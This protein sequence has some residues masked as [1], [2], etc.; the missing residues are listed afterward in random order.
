MMCR[1]KEICEEA[2]RLLKL[3]KGRTKIPAR[4]DIYAARCEA[5]LQLRFPTAKEEQSV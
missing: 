2:L 4:A 3:A 5:I 1:K